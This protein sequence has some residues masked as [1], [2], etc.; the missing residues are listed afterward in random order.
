MLDPKA[1]DGGVAVRQ[2][3]SA[4]GLGMGEVR[5]VEVHTDPQPAGP[6]DPA[7]KVDRLDL[8]AIDGFPARLEVD[9]VQV[10]PVAARNQAEGLPGVAAE[11][12]GV[13]G[14]AGIAAGGHDPAA[15]EARFVFKTA[16]VVALPAVH[17]D[18]DAAESL[19]RPVGIDAEFGVPLP[20][21]RVHLFNGGQNP[22][23]PPFSSIFFNRRHGRRHTSS[24]CP[25][26]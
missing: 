3:E 21:Q 2:R 18:R 25:P 9:G 10:E 12:V 24:R 22:Q 20:G 7:G 4:G 16:H 5:R 19:Q 1:A 11:F 15:R 6:V 26:F 8:V 23:T 17:G 13:T 14:L